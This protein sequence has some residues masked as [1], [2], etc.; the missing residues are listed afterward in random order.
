[1]FA[2]NYLA[3]DMGADCAEE[4]YCYGVTHEKGSAINRKFRILVVKGSALKGVI[5]TDVERAFDLPPPL[6]PPHPAG[7]YFN[8]RWDQLAQLQDLLDPKIGAYRQ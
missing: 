8:G 7:V 2:P 3:M 6:L 4:E 1:M 5:C